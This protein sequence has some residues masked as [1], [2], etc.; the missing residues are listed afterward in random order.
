MEFGTVHFFGGGGGQCASNNQ[1]S[2]SLVYHLHSNTEQTH[3]QKKNPCQI[4][5]ILNNPHS[6]TMWH[7]LYDPN[8]TF[9]L[10]LFF[11]E[12]STKPLPLPI[13]VFKNGKVFYC[14]TEYSYFLKST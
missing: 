11:K 13:Q 7:S 2:K 8:N 6:Q 10:R 14:K 1:T 3:T 9:I 5:R 12:K 4:Y